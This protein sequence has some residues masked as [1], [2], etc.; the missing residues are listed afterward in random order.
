MKY[1]VTIYR[2]GFSAATF[3]IDAESKGEAE[4]KA[5]EQADNILFNEHS[6]E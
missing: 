2:T 4:K 3:V 1:K 5:Y 6:Y